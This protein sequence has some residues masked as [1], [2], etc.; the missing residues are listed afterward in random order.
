MVN[1]T[2]RE[3]LVS[4]E[5]SLRRFSE[6]KIDWERVIHNV[7]WG[8]IASVGLAVHEHSA[9]STHGLDG[10]EDLLKRLDYK[11]LKDLGQHLYKST[12]ANIRVAN[13]IRSWKNFY[14]RA[15]YCCVLQEAML[16]FTYLVK[17]KQSSFTDGE[18][19]TLD[20]IKEGISQK[21]YKLEAILSRMD[22]VE[23]FRRTR[24]CKEWNSLHPTLTFFKR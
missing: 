21:F 17:V 23:Q 5:N 2:V 12:K 18:G 8:C 13:K 4:M 6:G 15:D 16:G 9:D 1:G 7:S 14:R 10:L 22:Y 24:R 20:V 11:F 19:R 3:A